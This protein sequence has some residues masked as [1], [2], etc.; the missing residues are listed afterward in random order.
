[1]HSRIF[2]ISETP[3]DQE[4][5]LTSEDCYDTMESIADYITDCDREEGIA[6]LMETISKYAEFTNDGNVTSFVL[7]DDYLTKHFKERHRSFVSYA[8]KLYET[9]FEDFCMGK[10]YMDVVKFDDEFNRKYEF[11][12]IQENEADTM[13]QFMRYAESGKRYYVGAVLDYHW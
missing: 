10:A 8:K 12:F 6:W 2:Q 13:D 1:M 4:D 9:S 5:Y 7:S 3:V 11:Y